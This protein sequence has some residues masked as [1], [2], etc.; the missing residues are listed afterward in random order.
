MSW[1]NWAA[2][3]EDTSEL[4]PDV[5]FQVSGKTFSA[6]KFLM[7]AASPT[8]RTQFYGSL[9]DKQ[10]TIVVTDTTPEAFQSLLDFV[11]TKQSSD[12]DWPDLSLRQLFD[13]LKLADYYLILPLKDLVKEEI[14]N[15]TRCDELTLDT[16]FEAAEVAEDFKVF[17]IS[18][19][20]M[21][22][23]QEFLIE[24]VT[25]EE[26]VELNTNINIDPYVLS[27]VLLGEKCSNC[28]LSVK[29]CLDGKRVTKDNLGIGLKI[30]PAPEA[31][32]VEGTEGLGVITGNGY[33][34]DS[35]LSNWENNREREVE[36][37]MTDY[38]FV[39]KCK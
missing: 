34:E 38:N 31:T 24:N 28:K 16:V 8:L 17:D 6:H 18:K 26:L 35:F 32:H 21:K 27:K 29:Q 14:V 11:Y 3:L 33:T 37:S 15:R 12:F 19:D 13:L 25:I 10:E 39:Y 30:K 22:E 2:F 36:F 4:P 7:A 1:I 5:T 9:P 20:I 23:C